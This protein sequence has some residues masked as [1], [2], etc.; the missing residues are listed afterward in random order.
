MTIP[1][2]GAARPV[3]A[4]PGPGD[5]ST[6]GRSGGSSSVTDTSFLT[7]SPGCLFP[8][9]PGDELTPFLV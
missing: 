4:L 2:A 6:S 3:R 7:V 9:D 1:H 8:G 5:S